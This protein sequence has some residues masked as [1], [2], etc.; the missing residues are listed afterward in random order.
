VHHHGGDLALGDFLQLGDDLVAI[1]VLIVPA[2]ADLDSQGAGQMLR[3]GVHSFVE[4]LGTVEESRSSALAA[5]RIDGTAAIQIHE[6]GLSFVLENLAKEGGS[7]AVRSGQEEVRTLA[8][9]ESSLGCP[10]AIWRP[11]KV[12][13][14]CRLSSAHSEDCP[15][16]MLPA[17]AIWSESEEGGTEGRGEE[18]PRHK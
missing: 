7:G 8:H 12:S 15:A 1:G 17:I 9:K 10:E 5:D 2:S 13:D 3:Q 18:G 6:I 4:F 14:S 16:L 11:N